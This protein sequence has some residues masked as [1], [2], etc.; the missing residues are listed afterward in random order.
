MEKPTNSMLQK[1]G[2][3][4]TVHGIYHIIRA[5]QNFCHKMSWLLVILVSLSLFLWQCVHS[6]Q[7]YYAFNTTVAITYKIMPEIK[8]PAIS[9]CN[10]NYLRR[11]TVGRSEQTRTM[12][13]MMNVN[14]D[15]S[16]T[17]VMNRVI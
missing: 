4:T 16:F 3:E 9:L 17:I 8:F 15:Q 14:A 7:L 2:E 12:V 6:F 5:G 10:S 11:S 13:A 1:F